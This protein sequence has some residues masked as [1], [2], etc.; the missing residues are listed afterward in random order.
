MDG[1]EDKQYDGGAGLLFS[2]DSQRVAYVA[3]VGE[4]QFV[5]VDGK[6]GN[7]YDGGAGLLFSP[8][9]QR[10]AYAAKA[11]KKWLVVVDGKEE[12]QYDRI[13]E[14]SP[15]FSPAGQ[16]V[17]YVAGVVEKWV[18]VV[19]GKEGNRYDVILPTQNRGIAFDP[20]NTL[21]YVAMKLDE[22]RLSFNRVEMTLSD[23]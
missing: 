13:G 3:G 10:V 19:D 9:G 15:I 23:S 22:E 12:N 11:G 18:V 17:A 5:V 20:S 14:G 2:P 7:Q 21:R 8:D 6:E 16:R 4:R 1:K